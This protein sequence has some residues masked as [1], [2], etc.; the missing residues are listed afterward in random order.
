MRIRTIFSR[1]ITAFL[2]FSLILM[3]ADFGFAQDS[4]GYSRTKLKSL[5]AVRTNDACLAFDAE[6]SGPMKD[7]PTALADV[8]KVHRIEGVVSTILDVI[9]LGP[10]RY[11]LQMKTDSAAACRAMVKKGENVSVSVQG[12]TG[13]DDL[14]VLPDQRSFQAGRDFALPKK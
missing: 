5:S 10:S 6:Y 9:R 2:S 1:R 13:R 7:A 14:P 11:R 12:G 3:R 4:V 8:E